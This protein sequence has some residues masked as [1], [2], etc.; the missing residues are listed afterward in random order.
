MAEHVNET[1]LKISPGIPIR[2]EGIYRIPAQAI[3]F[4]DRWG[5]MLMNERK[6]IG[7]SAALENVLCGRYSY[8]TSWPKMTEEEW[9]AWF[10]AHPLDLFQ[11]ED[12][13]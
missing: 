3:A 2:N 7:N 9:R 8:Y 6:R 1:P 13:D 11:F 4:W 5:R 10:D 12:D